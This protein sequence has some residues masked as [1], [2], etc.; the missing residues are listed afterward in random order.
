MITR[1]VDL[2][3]CSMRS[4]E[5]YT[6]HFHGIWLRIHHNVPNFT[7]NFEKSGSEFKATPP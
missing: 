2:F 6:S 7:V 1:D 4:L 5:K 3:V